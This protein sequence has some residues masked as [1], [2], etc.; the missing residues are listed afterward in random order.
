MKFRIW[1]SFIVLL[2]LI[3]PGF[4]RFRWPKWKAPPLPHE[5]GMT[6]PFLEITEDLLELASNIINPPD[7][8]SNTNNNFL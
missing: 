5:P 7:Y 8:D 3:V 4:S 6:G 2:W 1:K